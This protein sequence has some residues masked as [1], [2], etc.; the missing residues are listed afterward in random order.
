MGG[1]LTHWPDVVSR[2]EVWE[3]NEDGLL[4]VGGLW[5]LCVMVCVGVCVNLMVCDDVC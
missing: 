2:N 4:G 3:L 1:A 5:S